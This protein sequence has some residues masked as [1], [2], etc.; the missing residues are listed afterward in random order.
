V[1]SSLID[2]G[3]REEE[4]MISRK[5]LPFHFAS[6]YVFIIIPP[7]CPALNV[8]CDVHFCVRV[9]FE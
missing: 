6:Y 5:Q 8:S 7:L 2:G 3:E 4:M 1:R 9:Y